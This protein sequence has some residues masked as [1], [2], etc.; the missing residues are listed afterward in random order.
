MNIRTIALTGKLAVV[1]L[2]LMMS[3]PLA[4]QQSFTVSGT[5]LD[6]TKAPVPGATAVLLREVDSVMQNFSFT[7]KNGAFLMKGVA[8]GNYIMQV[9][10]VAFLSDYRKVEV[11][12][13]NIAL[14]GIRMISGDNSLGEVVIEG[15]RTPIFMKGDTVEY[16]ADAFSVAPNATVEDLLK[17]LPGVEVDQD[18]TVKAQGEEV[19]RVLVDGKE[20][21]GTDPKM[22]TKNLPA[23]AV[24]AVQVFDQ[25]SDM[26]QFTGVDDG[27]RQKTINLSLKA[28]KKKGYFGTV[29][30]GYGVS[31]QEGVENPYSGKAS[32]NKFSKN[33]QLSF[34]GQIN[35]TNQQGFS[36]E[37]YVGFSGGMGGLR[38]G[39]GGGRGGG[40][41]GIQINSDMADGFVKTGAAGLNLN[42]EF[43]KNT[44]LNMSYFFN[45]VRRDIDSDRTRENFSESGNFY[46][47]ETSD[48]FNQNDNHRVNLRFES[49]FDSTQQFIVRGSAAYIEGQS[50]SITSSVT[51]DIEGRQ[52][53][54]SDVDNDS[55]ADRFNFNGEISYRKLL[56]RKGRNLS[57]SLNAN[58]NDNERQVLLESVNSFFPVGNPNVINE[59]MQRQLQ[60]NDQFSYQFQASYTEPLGKKRYLEFNASHRNYRNNSD[61]DF[62]DI[63]GAVNPIEALNERLSNEFTNNYTYQNLGTN[64]R[65]IRNKVNFTT[66]LTLQRSSLNGEVIGN[67]APIDQEFYFLLP[68]ANMRVEFGSSKNMFFDYRTNVNEPSLEQLQ[69]VVDNSDPLNIY[70]GNPQLRPDFSH[71]IRARYFSFSQ[72]SFTSFFAFL[73]ATYTAN[74]IV[75]GIRIDESL[76]RETRPINV[77]NGFR[78]N[79][80]SNFSTPIRSLGINV[81]LNGNLAY[82]RG[83]QP[84]QEVESLSEP[85]DFDNT[86]SNRYTAGGGIKLDNR[87]K[88]VIDVIVGTN[89]NYNITTFSD[90]SSQD[91]E[92]INQRFY[93]E[94]GLNIGKNM[95]F[96]TEIDHTIYGGAAFG[97]EETITIWKASLSRFIMKN[98]RGE[99]KFTVFDLL[100]QNLGVNRTSTLNYIQEERIITLGQYFMFSFTYN[101]SKLGANPAGLPSNMRWMGR[102]RR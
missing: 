32:I 88:D 87:K 49:K 19:Q 45:S 20:F 41:T 42:H 61:I 39:G 56:N 17:R 74:D 76:R 46:L 9:S 43:S 71:S 96:S 57:V 65:I 80:F 69:P 64:F 91:Q 13:Q 6:S 82:N 36:F 37:D 72:F 67:G 30:A 4:A 25:Q 92:Y 93:G 68:S 40:G 5:I 83:I 2:L 51:T 3:T 31:G 34:L 78:I 8:P 63:I 11:R 59:I 27:T 85:V 98:K 33:T 75:N 23:D 58:G 102:R 44:E 24:D 15:E 22:A 38:R 97:E 50:N 12:D 21:F 52:E 47:E 94:I 77:D 35:N 79:G 101:L 55:N 84:L 18:G 90:A 28:D 66:G 48:A 54:T 100:N 89:I 81:N 99:L 14:G 70:I 95:R 73:N 62:Y 10:H 16:K 53:N 86:V 1:A 29:S 7:D 26:A 60:L